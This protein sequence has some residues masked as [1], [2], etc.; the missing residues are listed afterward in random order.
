MT[1]QDQT[2]FRPLL[3]IVGPTAA[4]KSDLALALAERFRGE[5]VNADSRQLYRRMNVGTAKPSPD[6]QRRVPHHLYSV[7]EPN[8]PLGLACYLDLARRAIAEVNSRDRL[9]ILVGGSGQYVLAL[10]E[11]WDVPRTRPDA[12]LRAGLQHDA[13]TQGPDALH[14]RLRQ[15]DPIAAAS[16]DPRNV[17]RVIRALEVHEI[18]GGLF[19]EARGRTAPPFR[20]LVLGLTTVTRQA[21][22]D[23]IDRRVDAMLAEGWLEETR[24]L[25]EAG[26][27]D[28]PV[29]RAS[30][31][32]PELARVLAG[33]MTLDD[34]RAAI[35]RAHHRL[36]RSQYTWFRRKDLSVHWL[37]VG[38]RLTEAAQTLVSSFLHPAPNP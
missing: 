29:F 38:P 23:R 27:G 5:I 9:P 1:T 10:L 28:T 30:M 13:H 12:S 32:Y 4:G 24:A 33:D 20:S 21:L 16:I 6:A 34:A 37:T 2:D 22:H 11:G 19:S 14:A 3:A 31:G 8:E 15:V 35:K 36:A 26:F 17:R 18:T 7:A 25:T